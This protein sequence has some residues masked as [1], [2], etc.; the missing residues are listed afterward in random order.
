MFFVPTGQLNKVSLKPRERFPLAT[1]TKE[2][3]YVVFS[4]R[5]NLITEVEEREREE[6]GGGGDYTTKTFLLVCF[7]SI[8]LPWLVPLAIWY[9]LM[10]YIFFLQ[11][12][13][14]QNAWNTS[15]MKVWNFFLTTSSYA[16]YY[17]SWELLH[18]T[19]C[20]DLAMACSFMKA[21]FFNQFILWKKA[22]LK[23]YVFCCTDFVFASL[24][25][26]GIISCLL[27]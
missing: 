13:S 11:C 2:M 25:F 26:L 19:V 1:V 22:S 6:G 16:F 24:F 14:V 9:L 12:I 18:I 5:G 21:D 4:Y 10:S 3:R 15:C 17:V 23:I 8:C 20:C 7:L 27:I